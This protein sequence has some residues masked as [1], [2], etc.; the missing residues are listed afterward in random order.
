M[1]I[2]KQ[3]ALTLAGCI[4][5]LGIIYSCSK[6]FLEK[7]PVGSLDE[8]TLQNKAGVNGLLIAGY[9]LLDGAGLDDWL[10]Q[11]AN[12]SVWNAWAGSVASDDAH[13]GGG[14][15][16]QPERGELE[17][18]KYT[19]QN[20]ILNNRWRLYYAGVQRAND[21]IRVLSKVPESELTEAERTQILAE[22]RFLRG[23]YHLQAAMMWRNIPFVDETVTVSANN[24]KV[25]NTP[26]GYAWPLIEAD[27]QFAA[28]NLTD[29]KTEV[30]R[31]N[32]YAAEAFL[33]KTYMMQNK[34]AEAKPL[35]QDLIDNGMNSAGRKYGL[36]DQFNK[37]FRPIYEN[38]AEDVEGVF[39]V[40]MSVN[41]GGLG[42][43]GNEG[44]SFNYP[45]WIMGGWGHQPSFDLVNAY[46]TQGGLPMLDNYSD[47]DVKNDMGLAL[48]V[49]FTP[50]TGTLD[51]RLDWTVARRHIP[52]HDHGR[53]E[54]LFNDQGGPY[55]GKKWIHWKG[56]EGGK[57]SEVIDGWQQANG[58]NYYMIRFADVL[59]WAAEVEVEIGDLQTAENYVNM[60]RN[61]AAN[62]NG[63]LKEYNDNSD[64][65]KGFSNTNAANYDVA[66]YGGA[67]GFVANG[68][69]YARK[70]VRFERRL[71][72]AMEGHR[73]FD[74]QRWSIADPNYM[75]DLLNNY[76]QKE[77]QRWVNYLGVPYQIFQ[78]ATFVKGKHE[79]Y[80][81]PQLQ[82]D[83]SATDDGPTL[84]QNPGF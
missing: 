5:G 62:P 4:M 18:K 80:A 36:M 61:R 8:I 41:D 45:S 30:G 39:T 14:Y 65:S 73:F 13:K 17:G 32:S 71:E 64:P 29:T 75:A 21:V 9:A 49:P 70:A 69:A 15:V 63:F 53:Q 46:K 44:E 27:F 34:L 33:V 83:Q 78:N 40:Q 22:A 19:P 57:T 35:L 52:F 10:I 59:L 81:I 3:K 6:D 66:P 68:Q 74:L 67:T 56:D 76:M 37:L 2:N 54:E 28:D 38:T 82:I 1:K 11:S 48:D 16:G 7:P 31:A 79:I 77:N 55:R 58:I 60:V 51:P 20:D 47:V 12:T 25:V 42:R 26:G 23:V 72:L 24:F 43:N 50:E 84:Q